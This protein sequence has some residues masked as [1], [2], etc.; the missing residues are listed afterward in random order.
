MENYV[1]TTFSAVPELPERFRTTAVV[2]SCVG[3]VMNPLP[4]QGK[5]QVPSWEELVQGNPDALKM[6]RLSLPYVFRSHQ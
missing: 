4:G 6:L 3:Q 1:G 2:D 5:S